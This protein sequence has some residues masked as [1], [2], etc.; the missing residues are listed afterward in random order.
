MMENMLRLV[1]S[2][3]DITSAINDFRPSYHQDFA[4]VQSVACRYLNAPSGSANAAL[5]AQALSTALRSWGACRRRSPILRPIP[6]IVSA[7][8]DRRLH[9][10][11]LKLSQQSLAAFSLYLQEHRLLDS[12]APLNDVGAFDQEILGI[13]NTL[14]S[15]LFFNNTNVTYPMKALL[16]ITGLIPALDSQVRGGLTRAGKAGFTGQQLLPR[17]VQQAAGRRICELP[18]YLGHCWNLHREVFEEGILKS[19]H[20]G[21]QDTP[22]RVFDILLFMQNQATR[23]QLLVFKTERV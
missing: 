9:E 1:G 11:L 23:N 22:G 14:A 16:L 10:R 19:D 15:V 5:L 3:L 4:N 18:Y 7:L 12:D 13:L 21:L 8:K 2:S 17:N 20:K 6:Q